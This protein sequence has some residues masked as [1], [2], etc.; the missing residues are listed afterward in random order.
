MDKMTNN[1]QKE[2]KTCWPHCQP[3]W[4]RE[5]RIVKQAAGERRLHL[6]T[7]PG[8]H[9]RT[10]SGPEPERA[11]LCFIS[12][13]F[14]SV[15][16]ETEVRVDAVTLDYLVF[17]SLIIRSVDVERRFNCVVWRDVTSISGR[18]SSREKLMLSS[19]VRM[20]TASSLFWMS[21][22]LIWKRWR[23]VKRSVTAD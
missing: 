13:S 23:E 2:V 10:T 3:D 14:I 18:A 15:V 11:A 22:P 4:E 9:V 8:L 6:V 17:C 21:T 12:A 7:P 5:R 1:R 16:N 20:A 19:R